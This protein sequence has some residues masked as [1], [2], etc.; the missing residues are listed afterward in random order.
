MFAVLPPLVVVTLL[1][2]ELVATRVNALGTSEEKCAPGESSKP[3]NSILMFAVSAEVRSKWKDKAPTP[4]RMAP[5]MII[6]AS[7]FPLESAMVSA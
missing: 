1:A 6:G 2:L 3:I 5:S 4:S 7:L